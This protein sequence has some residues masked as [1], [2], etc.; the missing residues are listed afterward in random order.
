MGYSLTTQAIYGLYLDPDESAK[1]MDAIQAWLLTDA[2]SNVRAH[3][4]DDEDIF[5]FLEAMSSEEEDAYQVV[6]AAEESDSRIHNT[7]YEEDFFHGF[8]ILLAEKGEDDFKSAVR[9][10]ASEEQKAIFQQ[11][12]GPIVKLAGLDEMELGTVIVSYTE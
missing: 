10:G 9:Q 11:V 4:D 5:G 8:G 1:L 12:L 3:M 6:M 7:R 2:G